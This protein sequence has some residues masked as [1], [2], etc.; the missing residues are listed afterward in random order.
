MH[1]GLRWSRSSAH[2]FMHAHAIDTDLYIFCK[3]K[4]GT[5]MARSAVVA[6]TALHPHPESCHSLKLHVTTLTL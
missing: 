5:A 2:A 4:S 3:V 1:S 6:P